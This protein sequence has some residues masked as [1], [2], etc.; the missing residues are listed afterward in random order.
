MKGKFS[1][2]YLWNKN[3]MRVFIFFA[4]QLAMRIVFSVLY[5][6]HPETVRKLIMYDTAA[7]LTIFLI[8][9]MP[10]IRWIFRFL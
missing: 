9:F 1:E 2:A 4:V 3:G 8:A 6:K 7:S 5:L 10:F